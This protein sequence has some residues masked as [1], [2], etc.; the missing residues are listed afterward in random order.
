MTGKKIALALGGRRAGRGW[1]ALCPA[2]DD[3]QPSFSISE[4]EDGR[5]LVHCFAG[6]SQERVIAELRALDL[7]KQANLCTRTRP[8]PL[9]C[10]GHAPDPSDARRTE[11]ALA[12]WRSTTLLERTPVEVY[13]AT[14]GLDLPTLQTVRFHKDLRHPSGGNWPAMIAL[15]TR[16]TDNI[17]MAVH[18]TWLAGNGLGKAPVEPQRA[19]LGPCRGGAVRLAPP[20]PIMM[21]G[22]GIENAG[23]F[24]VV[25]ASDSFQASMPPSM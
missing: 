16:G 3:S 6:C 4:S 14:R 24:L 18:R 15:V 8:M 9:G 1:L 2:H 11:V 22:E 20:G 7:W 19:M 21:I 13:L 17:P 10:R 25:G 12:I 5:V 23:S